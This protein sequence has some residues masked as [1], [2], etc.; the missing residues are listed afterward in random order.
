[1]PRPEF[2]ELLARALL[3]L[4]SA[5]AWVVHGADGIDEISTTG[6]TKISECRDGAVN[7][8]YLHPADVGLSKA[9][10]AAIRGGTAAENARMVTAILAGERGA[11]RDIVVLNAGAALF[12]AGEAR[13]VKDGMRRAAEA[14]DEGGA[15]RTLSRMAEISSAADAA[16][17]AG[18]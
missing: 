14:I 1:V 8:F 10:P 7:T 18:A 15:A 3:L 9:P 13:S 11:P 16:A 17:G 6:Y 4:G 2:T 5:R 12:I